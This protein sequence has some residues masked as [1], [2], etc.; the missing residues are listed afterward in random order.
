MTIET[1]TF[2]GNVVTFIGAAAIFATPILLYW[3]FR[4]YYNSPLRK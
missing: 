3:I 2:S 4:S 1:Y